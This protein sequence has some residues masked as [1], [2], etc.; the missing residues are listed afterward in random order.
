MERFT[1]SAAEAKRWSVVVSSAPVPALTR[2]RAAALRAG[3]AAVMLD[4][5]FV[6]PIKG[7]VDVSLGIV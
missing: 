4:V 7:R 2:A 6:D 5:R 3:T 1:C